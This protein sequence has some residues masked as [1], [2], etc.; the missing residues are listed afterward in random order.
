MLH[1]DIDTETDSSNI[2]PCPK[3]KLLKLGDYAEVT[4]K[5]NLELNHGISHY[6]LDF[7]ENKVSVEF[8]W[9]D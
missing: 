3:T 1:G 2:K 9:E 5:C 4:I 8:R 7:P 6:A